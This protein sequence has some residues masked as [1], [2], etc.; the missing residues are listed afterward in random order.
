[1]QCLTQSAGVQCTSYQHTIILLLF[2]Y[3]PAIICNITLSVSPQPAL[4]FHPCQVL[5]TYY[6]PV[7]ICNITLSVYPQQAQSFHPCQVLPAYYFP[8]YDTSSLEHEVSQKH[9]QPDPLSVWGNR[10]DCQIHQILEY[11]EYKS[12]ISRSLQARPFCY[13]TKQKKQL[14]CAKIGNSNKL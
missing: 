10:E 13:Y 11:V 7:I 5:P 1:M 4:S 9:L 14:G 6:S 3:S 8:G 2:Y 12:L